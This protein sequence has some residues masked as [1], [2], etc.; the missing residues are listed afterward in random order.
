MPLPIRVR[1]RLNRWR[2]AIKNFF[3]P[4]RSEQTVGRPRICPNCG[5]LVGSTAKNCFSCGANVSFSM[6]AAS[7]SLTRLLPQTSPATY[8]FLTLCCLMYGLSFVLTIRTTG[9]PPASGGLFGLGGIAGEVVD[10]LGA[11]RPWPFDLMQPWRLITAIFLHGALLHIGFNMWIL[12][13]LG[14]VV[15][16]LYGSARFV[17]IFVFTGAFGYLV[18][19]FFG[20]FSVGAS[21]SLLGLIG[22]LLAITSRRSGI[23]MQMLRKQL[24]YWLIYIAVLGVILRGTDNFAHAGGFVSGFLL[25]K[26]HAG[27]TTVRHERTAGRSNTGVERRTR[28]CC[29]FWVHA[30]RLFRPLVA[31]EK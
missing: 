11:S 26:A 7:K 22:V 15:E 29:E 14:P 13:D 20:N 24:I 19:S 12:M 27:S 23:G 4:N 6:A 9:A 10:K 18:S 25:G 28:H 31:R 30:P 3:R 2:D 16:E 21:G 17:F 8:A 1:Y 5:T